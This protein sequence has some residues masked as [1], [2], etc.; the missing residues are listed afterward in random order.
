MNFRAEF[1]KNKV[2]MEYEELTAAACCLDPK[3]RDSLLERL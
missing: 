2:G 3:S 1:T